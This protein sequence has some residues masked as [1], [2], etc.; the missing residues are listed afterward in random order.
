M[1]SDAVGDG[2]LDDR[3]RE[4]VMLDTPVL[5]VLASAGSGKTRV[6][7]Q[8]V[9]RR[10]HDRTADVSRTLVLTFTR[11]AAGELRDRLA[12]LDIT[13]LT[14]GT[15]HGIALRQLREINDG[16]DAGAVVAPLRIVERLDERL[17]RG[18][19][20]RMIA[21][22]IAWAKARAVTP[23]MYE[24]LHRRAIMP[25][26]A[27][28][29]LFEAYEREKHRR[30]AMDFDDMLLRLGD[31]IEQDPA[32]AATQCWR[33]RHIFVDEFQDLNHAQFRLLR[34]WAGESPDVFVVGDPYQAIYGWNGAD[35]SFIQQFGTYFPTAVTIDL[36]TNYR[37]T[38]PIL[39]AA[40]AV[41]PGI[42]LPPQDGEDPPT[43]ES[44]PSD[45]SEAVGIAER[46]L[47]YRR[48]G[49]AWREMAVLFRT[50]AQRPMLVRALRERGIDV[51]G[52]ASWT[53]TPEV[54]D[55]L[56]YLRQSI[57]AP[58]RTR[59]AD[60][61]GEPAVIVN[62]NS[63]V[64][65]DGLSELREAIADALVEQ[66]MMTIREFLAW[67]DVTTRFDGPAEQRGVS[68]TTLHRA[69]GLEWPVV[70]LA[71]VEDGFLPLV[72]SR[73]IDEEKRLFYVGIT[74]AQRKLH[75]SWARARTLSM[76]DDATAT[77]REISPWL[78]DV[79]RA[80]NDDAS[81]GVTRG[82][83]ARNVAELRDAL[84]DPS[85]ESVEDDENVVD[86]R[87]EARDADVD[88]SLRDRLVAW[89]RTSAK[90][91]NVSPTVILSDEE[92]EA[93]VLHRPRNLNELLACEEIRPVRAHA[94]ADEVCRLVQEV[95]PWRVAH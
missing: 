70:F 35:S 64:G 53:Q 22:E 42:E 54:I 75:I 68:V 73:D 78:A 37:S 41:I 61:R 52:G 66:P 60:L 50:N 19:P 15:F 24:G 93:I 77:P 27:F 36:S 55:T 90:L 56:S 28:A 83:L 81:S 86:I 59:V 1:P 48:E 21:S 30:R 3:Q 5:R 7:T 33:F 32:V 79:V 6:L 87:D 13:G 23:T 95:A 14:A 82:E 88:A 2:A 4:A 17:R 71:G 40:Q 84:D 92:C 26:G 58:L 25:T 29:R 20:S 39:R 62:E 11:K 38:Y 63:A 91:V 57:D 43:V 10:I 31:V 74:R 49:V 47:R 51:A 18:V 94:L 8:R 89:R 12:A 44:W 34:L 9:A 76:R 72:R 65:E 67:L 46:V 69:K 85:V 80:L 16:R 45:Q